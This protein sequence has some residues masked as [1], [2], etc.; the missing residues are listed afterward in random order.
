MKKIIKQNNPHLFLG[1]P[2]TEPDI[3]SRENNLD[4]EGIY[5]SSSNLRENSHRT[6]YVGQKEKDNR[7]PISSRAE[8]VKIYFKF[9]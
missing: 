1:C 6:G 5:K 8:I 2:V 4:I 3:T 9:N 7:E